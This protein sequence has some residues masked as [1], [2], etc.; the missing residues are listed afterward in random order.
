MPFRVQVDR[1]KRL[2]LAEFYG[3]LSAEDVREY[4]FRVWSND[5]LDGFRELIDLRSI[6]EESTSFT[7]I[8]A[9]AQET[10]S[11]SIP[12]RS[13]RLALVV[14]THGQAEKA[15]FFGTARATQRPGCADF[16]V[17]RSIELAERWLTEAH[18]PAPTSG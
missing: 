15:D 5:A 13:D 4:V 8:L 2:V 7:E 3:T 16:Q 9:L 12:V 18:A 17:F 11:L 14:S 10:S 1:D 6:E